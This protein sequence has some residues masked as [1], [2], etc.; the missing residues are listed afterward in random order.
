L[1]NTGAGLLKLIYAEM[2]PRKMVCR[3]SVFSPGA[4]KQII[5]QGITCMKAAFTG[6]VE[7]F[8][9]L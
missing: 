8:P 5:K 1:I 4:E 2:P 7:R 6:A 3:Q 9:I